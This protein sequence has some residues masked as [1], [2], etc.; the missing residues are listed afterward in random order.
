MPVTSSG[1]KR[2]RP[3][4]RAIT[5]FHAEGVQ[6]LSNFH[7]CDVT[8]DGV[9]YP[10]AEAAFQAAKHDSDEHRE[11]V[12]SRPKPRSA[13]GAGGRASFKA[14]G[15][16]LREDW[17]DVKVDVMRTVVR[18]KFTQN[19]ELASALL[20]TGD[21]KLAEGNTWGDK[22]WGVTKHGGEN[23]LGRILMQVRGELADAAA[24]AAAAGEQAGAGGGGAAEAAQ[25]RPRR[26]SG[27]ARRK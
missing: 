8:V 20:G 4:S 10:T 1:T 25:P 12:R 18:A 3:S 2:A 26:G 5:D 22:F 14:R 27:K 23:W 17:E 7:E 11:F 21:V 16:T 15:I 9:T 19:A 13:K 6:W 24:D